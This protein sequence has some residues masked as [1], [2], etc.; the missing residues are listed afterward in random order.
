MRNSPAR[1]KGRWRSRGALVTG[2][3]AVALAATGLVAPNA[4][5]AD[6]NQTGTNNG[7][8]YSNWSDGQGTVNFTLGS[9]GNYS[10]NWSNVGNFVGG[11]GWKP[12]GRKVVNYSGTWSSS[13]NSYLALYGWTTNPLV[14]YYIVDN[15]GSYNPST[16]ATKLGTV[17]SD[18]GVYDIYR[19]QRVN[20]PSIQGT[21]TFYQYW[22]VRQQ[23]RTGGT[24]TTGNHFDAWSKSGLQ[25]G[26]FDYMIMATEGY[27][28]SG[29]SNITVSEGAS[30]GSTTTT[31][32][33]TTTSSSGGSSG[34]SCPNG[35]V[36][37]TYDDG[38][39]SNTSN[40]LSVLKQNNVRATFFNIGQKV[41]GNAAVARQ[42][43]TD[44]HWVGNHSWTHP[45]LINMS[46]SQILSELQQTQ[47]AIQ[48]AT[49]TTPKL[50]RPPYG[51]TNS[52]LKAVEQQLGLTEVIW[53]VDSQDWNGA[54]TA[55]IVS[56]AARL[57]NGQVI[58]MHDPYPNT[59][60]AA[61]PQIVAGLK[62][63]GLCPGMISP[64]TGRAVAPD[65]GSTPVTT[66]TTTT[67]PVVTTT[68]TQGQPVTTTT[69][70]GGGT[71]ACSASLKVVGSWSGG[72]QGEVTVTAG[73]S[74]ISKWTV[75]WSFPSGTAI[76]Q[77][78]N[79]N[80]SGTSSVTA[81]NVAFNGSLGAGASTSWGF[82]GSG[83]PAT[84][85]VS[86]TA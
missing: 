71:G 32:T 14:E 59:T 85:A 58:L 65:G 16:G 35:Y 68:T 62:S 39:T 79:A 48:S 51:E 86:C 26:N 45:H 76:S 3:V 17:T 63:R 34:W 60:T 78:W 4:A 81:S 82:I 69:N 57:T 50:F 41:G 52:T 1:P 10:Y 30:G 46:Q 72:W 18:G 66:T 77:S 83:S 37:L 15:F 5:Q 2:A 20:Q 56:A 29:S 6:V 11:K 8:F 28:S 25:L 74:S 22:S 19:T 84:P 80:V 9:G 70:G 21:A 54:S 23:K 24:I 40:L 31:T 43:I 33:T 13:G 55:S 53:D 61:I 12:G 27:K 49:G 47:T 75:G 73:S 44:G 7:Y 36:G 38:P 42:Q 64:S 67:R